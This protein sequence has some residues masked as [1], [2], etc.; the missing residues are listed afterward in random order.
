VLT[1]EGNRAIKAA[2]DREQQYMITPPAG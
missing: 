1:A 2:A